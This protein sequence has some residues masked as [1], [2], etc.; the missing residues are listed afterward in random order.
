M[1][2]G[3]T[4]RHLVQARRRSHAAWNRAARI[5]PVLLQGDSWHSAQTL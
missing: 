2:Q 1:C 5:V 4:S 3:L